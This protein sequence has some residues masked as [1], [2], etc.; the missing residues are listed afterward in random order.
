MELDR[1]AAETR[2][3]WERLSAQSKITSWL[4]RHQYSIMF[5]GWLTACAVA[6]NVIWKNK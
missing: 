5:G 6:G 1:E 4:V 3:A 2:A